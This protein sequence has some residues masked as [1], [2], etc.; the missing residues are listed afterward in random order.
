MVRT[1]G[2]LQGPGL[3]RAAQPVE[4]RHLAEQVAPLHER[5]H[6]LA[7]VDGALGDGDAAADDDVELGR[8]GVLGEEQVAAVH[9]GG[10][11]RG[12]DLGH[13]LVG[14]VGEEGHVAE[15]GGLGH[16]GSVPGRTHVT[17]LRVPVTATTDLGDGAL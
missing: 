13:L 1:C 10:A 17:G 7:P 11:G 9:V 8:L 3:G 2:G 16:R 14:E 15:Q 4:Q 12:L 6:R 5:H